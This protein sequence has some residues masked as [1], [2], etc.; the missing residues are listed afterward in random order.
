MAYGQSTLDRAI[1]HEIPS[2]LE[3][4]Q[5][6]HAHP[7]I[8]YQE[9]NT[10]GLVAKELRKLGFEVAERVG[11]YG[12][13]HRT[14]YGVVAV[15]RNGNG[16][17]VLVRTD[18]DALPLEE[19][20]GL[21]YASTVKEKN[22]SGE[23]VRVMHACGHDV[24]MTS[25]L[26]TARML[27]QMTDRWRGT[28]MLIA[29]PSEERG[30]GAKALLHDGLYA[31]F[32]K[33]D[34]VLALH[35]HASLEAGK[36][37]VCEGYALANVTSVDITV[38]GVGGHGAYPHT[39]KDPVVLASQIV[40][41]LQTIVSRE[42]SPLDPAVV[43]VGSIHGGT[44]HNI[45]PDEVRLQVTVRS[46]KEEVRKKI[47]ASIERIVRGTAAAAG[48]PEDRAPLVKIDESESIAATYNDPELT[49][50]VAKVMETA[51]GQE[52]VVL[53][54]P[55]MAGEDFGYYSLGDKI[56]LSLFWLGTVDP[57]K[58]EKSR[59]EGTQLPPLHS[60]LFAPLPGPTLRTGIKATTS[61]VLD[62]MKK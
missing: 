44:K 5:Y 22:D 11:K 45:I 17:T 15:M 62:L 24:H 37:G 20:T 14:S 40:L 46:Y 9:E 26:G 58:V 31:R 48:I 35:S 41:A 27:S 53:V 39:T 7:E 2:L 30:S 25:L 19:R 16:P 10:A 33:P 21:A 32:P 56:P 18:M 51:L 57:T 61:V 28:L 47:L 29:Q 12:E 50:R 54:E 60:S 49:R 55:T 38:R 36:V 6:L 3:T 8:S 52:N 1:E 4:Y 43:T 59:K 42:N 23:E 34:Y 13:P